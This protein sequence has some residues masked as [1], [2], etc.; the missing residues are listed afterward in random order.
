MNCVDDAPAHVSFPMRVPY[1]VRDKLRRESSALSYRRKPVSQCIVIPVK[2]G[3]QHP[4]V[5][6]EKAGIQ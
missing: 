5:I 1:Q 4:S 3:I 6:P 2:T